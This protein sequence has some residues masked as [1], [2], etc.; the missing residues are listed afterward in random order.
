MKLKIILLL[1]F[2]SINLLGQKQ[3]EV[4]FDFN[5]D[6]PNQSS[7]LEIN[8]WIANNKNVEIT[9]LLGYCDSID[10]KNYNKKLAE[11]RIE[12]VQ[13]LLKI[14]GLKFSENLEKLAIG[15]DF[16]RSNNQAINRKVTILYFEPKANILISESD[17]IPF[18]SSEI[19]KIVAIEKNILESKFDSKSKGDLIRLYGIQFHLNSTKII[20]PSLPLL[21]E[22]L[23]IMNDNPKLK[24][25]IQGHICCQFVNIN[26][27]LS[28]L[29]AKTIYKYLIQNNI[30]KTRLRYVGF[31]TLKPIYKIPEQNQMEEQGNRR[32]E[33]LIIE[34]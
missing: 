4:F 31:G 8:E 10:T 25:E 34:K 16:D 24:I 28:S 11:R 21:E 17:S 30:E 6:F 22:L 18:F 26:G 2:I 29:R 12:N 9:R 23:R 7:I 27:G 3:M 19:S 1:L 5:K 13:D 32:V 20:E 15:K 14:N 33:I